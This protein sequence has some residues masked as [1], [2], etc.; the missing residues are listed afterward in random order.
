MAEVDVQIGGRTFQVNCREGE[1]QFLQSAA[2]MLDDE[3]SA[4]AKQSGRMTENRM[5]LL[6]GLMLADKTAAV[7]DENRLL[8]DKIKQL[9]EGSAIG[10]SNESRP[11]KEGNNIS[12]IKQ[13]RLPILFVSEMVLTLITE[14]REKLRGDNR[15]DPKDREA[16]FAEL[17]I[18][19]E[20]AR[21]GQALPEVLPR[22]AS[23]SEIEKVDVATQRWSQKFDSALRE[24]LKKTIDPENVAS[25]AVP[26]GIILG[27]GA[28]G[29]LIAGPVGFGAGSVLGHLVT[30]QMKPGMAASKIEEALSEEGNELD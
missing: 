29:A 9:E 26:T 3:A 4:L 22:D 24:N 15:L 21:E 16:A 11:P 14:A 5:L 27:C 2:K 28:L 13:N 8:Q 25:V 6:C 20:L 12:R 19:S 23:E 17:D 7:E 1:E 30:G 18:L 10:V